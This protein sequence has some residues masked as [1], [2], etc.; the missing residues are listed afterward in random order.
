[1]S[2]IGCLF[3][4]VLAVGSPLRADI[5]VTF[6]DGNPHDRLRIAN[7][8]CAAVSGTMTVD[9]TTS[10]TGILLDTVRG[11][12]GTKDPMPVEVERG[13]LAVGPVADGARTL[14][15]EVDALQPGA[16]GVITMDVDNTSGWWPEQRIDV[17][18]EDIA[19]TTI[20]WGDAV[21]STRAD[22]T[23]RMPQPPCPEVP[24]LPKD[25]TTPSV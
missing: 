22:G 10:A 23:A 11:G 15:V 9:F 20:L 21:A 16:T 17:F 19:G 6:R 1:M 5:V 4:I 3:L 2:R 25:D 24:D 7:T 14:T 18:G 13:P 12:P 8:G